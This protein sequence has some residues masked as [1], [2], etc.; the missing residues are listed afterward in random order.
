MTIEP[1]MSREV[2]RCRPDDTLNDA[3]LQLWER[4]CGS[5]PVCSADEA[6]TSQVIGMLTDR[7]ICM[8]ALFQ[9]KPLHELKV[10]DAM[11]REIRVAKVDDRIEDV[12][13]LMREV[14]IR[15]VPVTDET[16]RLVGIVTLADF[17]RAARGRASSRRAGVVSERDVGHTLAAIC[18]PGRPR[19][20]SPP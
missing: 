11:S 8:A 12:E 7:D 20:E 10:A 3:A 6:G 15:R 16:G 9:G 19:M 1:L 18:D 5:L 2:Y 14:K 4:D 17:A 13:L